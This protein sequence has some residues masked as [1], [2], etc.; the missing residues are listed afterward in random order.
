MSNSF[1]EFHSSSED[2]M[3][4]LKPSAILLIIVAS[5][6]ANAQ[7]GATTPADDT[8]LRTQLKSIATLLDQTRQQL[9]SSQAEIQALRQEV[10]PLKSGA[11]AQPTQAATTPLQQQVEQIAE[12]QAVTDSR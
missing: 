12:T 8:D 2:A 1:P 9:Q 11:T 6:F 4:L 3:R 10:D 5:T 7:L